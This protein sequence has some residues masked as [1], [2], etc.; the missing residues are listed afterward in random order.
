MNQP[1]PD[2]IRD[3]ERVNRLA[4]I[5]VIVVTGSAS[6]ETRKAAIEAGATELFVKPADPAKL[7]DLLASY[8]AR[9]AG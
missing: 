4:E 8:A 3:F 6:S 2:V 9:R 1:L 5:P 7:A